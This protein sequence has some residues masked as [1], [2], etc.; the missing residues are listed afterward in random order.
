MAAK[1]GLS[2]KQKQFVA[3][4]LIDLNATQAAIRAGYSAKTAQEQG[5]RLLSNAMVAHAVADGAQKR[6]V[7]A[8]VT[9]QDV[10]DGL[11]REATRVGDGASHGARVQAWGLLG[12]YHKLFTDRIEGKMLRAAVEWR[13]EHP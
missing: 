3:E 7:K 5:S 12:K 4:Y 8:D 6:I 11:Y 10:I 13:E 9:A 2:D 1:T